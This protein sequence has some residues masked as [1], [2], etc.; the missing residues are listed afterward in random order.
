VIYSEFISTK[1]LLIAIKVEGVQS[2]RSGTIA[3]LFRAFN[4]YACNV[5]NAAWT[6]CSQWFRI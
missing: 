5:R 3:I 4:L 2:T 6:K 1:K